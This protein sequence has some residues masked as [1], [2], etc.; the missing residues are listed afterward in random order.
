MNILRMI[1]YLGE[2]FIPTDAHQE[3][4]VY[5]DATSPMPEKKDG[6]LPNRTGTQ[7]DTAYG[8]HYSA[9]STILGCGKGDTQENIN[10]F[11]QWSDQAINS[12]DG[13]S[14][15]YVHK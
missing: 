13:A 11:A 3:V 2:V 5:G 6:E 7:E 1:H 14:Y 8:F 12:E 10:K 4:P 15:V 9:S